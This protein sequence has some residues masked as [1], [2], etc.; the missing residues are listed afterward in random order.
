MSILR[1]YFGNSQQI[2]NGWVEKDAPG[3]LLSDLKILENIGAWSIHTLKNK[4]RTGE[5]TLAIS[6][7]V[8]KLASGHFG[9]YAG[10]CCYLFK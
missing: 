3:D 9:K 5:R 10:G 4:Q 1:T 2:L 6:S 8:Y 7:L